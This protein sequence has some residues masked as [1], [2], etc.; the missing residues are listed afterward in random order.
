MSVAIRFERL[1]PSAITEPTESTYRPR[2]AEAPDCGGHACE[3]PEMHHGRSLEAPDAG[4][5]RSS[6]V[7]S[8]F[9]H[10]RSQS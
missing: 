4:Y 10:G 3:A 6:Y 5:G 2:I 7:E 1:I 8:Q 9:T